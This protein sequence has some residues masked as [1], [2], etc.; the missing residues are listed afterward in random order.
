MGLSGVLV[1]E[2]SRR[3]AFP[4]GCCV[5]ACCVIGYFEECPALT[6]G[7]D[8]LWNVFSGE[9]STEDAHC[10]DTAAYGISLRGTVLEEMH[11]L[12][13]GFIFFKS[14]TYTSTYLLEE[15]LKPAFR[16]S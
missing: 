12:D 8:G 9:Q 3:V 7:I 4:V 11:E 5:T 13:P 1:V 16:V 15:R 14:H 2:E 10:K 6:C